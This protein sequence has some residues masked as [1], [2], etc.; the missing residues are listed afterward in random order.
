LKRL[1]VLD[2]VCEKWLTIGIENVIGPGL[3]RPLI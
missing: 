3:K 2:S 1:G